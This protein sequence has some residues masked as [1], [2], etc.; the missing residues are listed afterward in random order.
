MN[1][2]FDFLRENL[3]PLLK[4]SFYVILPLCL[5]QSFMLDSSMRVYSGAFD[6]D[7]RTGF[8]SIA[9]QHGMLILCTL[10]GSVLLS[11]LVY[12]LLRTY[13]RRDGHLQGLVFD[14]FRELFLVNCV[15][16]AR[17]TL[18]V[19]AVMIAAIAA[20]WLLAWMSLWTLAMTLPLLLGGLIAVM[21]PFALFTPLYLFEDL[22]FAAALRKSM[23][24]GFSAWGEIFLVMVVFGL[25][26]NIL[27]SM[28]SLPWTLLT[29][30]GSVLSISSSNMDIASSFWYQFLSYILGV[31]MAYGTYISMI[32]GTG[33]MAFQYFHLREKKEGVTMRTEI[34][35][36]DRL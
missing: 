29:I 36:F 9:S 20:V 11:A 30:V 4:F 18:F 35:N 7:G 8:V 2:T 28:T 1:V 33:G 23:K 22:P 12:S 24:Y 27:S 34:A 31:V 21:I 14:D 26:A 25:L 10:L 15:K 5:I 17:I 13:E 16:V 6:G 19:F 3:K 32:I